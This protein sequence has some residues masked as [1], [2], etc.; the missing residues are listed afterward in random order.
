MSSNKKKNQHSLK[1]IKRFD[2]D[3]WG[4]LAVKP[5]PTRV[6]N[7]LFEVYQNNYKYRRLLKKRHF[8]F[9]SKKINFLYKTVADDKEFR[10]KKRTMKI[11]NYLNQL[12]P[13][14]DNKVSVSSFEN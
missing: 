14:Y 2:E 13:K 1:I 4:W 6:L 11:N 10:K 8:F 7:Y 12:K 5:K 9:S 3:L